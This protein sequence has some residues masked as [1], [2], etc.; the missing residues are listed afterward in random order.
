[1]DP[2][3]AYCK[4]NLPQRPFRTMPNDGHTCT[5]KTA[6]GI[7]RRILMVMKTAHRLMILTN[8]TM[9]DQ[10]FAKVPGHLRGRRFIRLV[11]HATGGC[12]T[13]KYACFFV[14]F[15]NSHHVGTVC[16]A[17]QHVAS[18]IDDAGQLAQLTVPI[19]SAWSP[20]LTGP[21]RV[22]TLVIFEITAFLIHGAERYEERLPEEQ[23]NSIRICSSVS[24]WRRQ[25]RKIVGSHDLA[26]IS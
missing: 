8:R 11:L 4:A 14:V 19:F 1:M 3:S 20:N 7:C 10:I 15:G 26:S 23:A 18:S 9:V 2:W 17:M 24:Q 12:C 13:G 6:L 21:A 16:R 22:R 25:I 5:A